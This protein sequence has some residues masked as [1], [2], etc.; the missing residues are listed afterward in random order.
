MEKLVDQPKQETEFETVIKTEASHGAQTPQTD[1]DRG[2]VVA[3][4]VDAE[5]GMAAISLACH[6]YRFDTG[7]W[8][9][10]INDLRSV[11]SKVPVDPFGDGKQTL[12]YVLIKSGL[13]NG[14]D[15]PLTYSRRDSKD[16]LFFET[17]QPYF[18]YYFQR[19]KQG[20]QFR[21]IAAWSPRPG[22]PPVTQPLDR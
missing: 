9:T 12:G 10:S 16:G 14:D 19:P 4:R 8:P 2:V 6:L 21:D 1:I 13:P 7:R 5:C 3:K 15:R 17:D 22:V 18:S 20:G 11:I